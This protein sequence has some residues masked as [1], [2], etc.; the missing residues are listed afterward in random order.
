[1]EDGPVQEQQRRERLIL[2][3]R[4]HPSFH[5]ERREEARYFGRAHLGRVTLRMKH[6]VA[7]DPSQ[8]SALGPATVVAESERITDRVEQP[9][10]ARDEAGALA[11]VPRASADALRFARHRPHGGGEYRPRRSAETTLPRSRNAGT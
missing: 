10:L 3:R 5:G 6:D 11:H 2:R 1:A 4:A 8:V 7:P 9:G